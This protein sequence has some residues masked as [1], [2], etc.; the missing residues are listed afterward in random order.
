MPLIS[1]C[2]QFYLRFFGSKARFSNGI[3]RARSIPSGKN[4]FAGAN[5]ISQIM[6]IY[7]REP[8]S[9]LETCIRRPEAITNYPEADSAAINNLCTARGVLLSRW[10]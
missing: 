1:D 7:V 3:F 10:Q 5:A 6:K 2:S 8:K 9:C 4:T